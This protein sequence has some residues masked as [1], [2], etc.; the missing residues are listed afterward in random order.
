VNEYRVQ[1]ALLESVV[2]ARYAV[3]AFATLPLTTF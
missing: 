3:D 2:R 1:C